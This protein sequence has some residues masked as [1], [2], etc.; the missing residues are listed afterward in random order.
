MHNIMASLKRASKVAKSVVKK[1]KP[2]K[3]GKVATKAKK[4]AVKKSRT[5]KKSRATHPKLKQADTE[6]CFWVNNGPIIANLLDL[7]ETLDNMSDEQFSYHTLSRG[8][9]F[10]IWIEE[11]IC[12][13]VLAKKIAR[14]KSKDA[15]RKAIRT[16]LK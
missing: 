15:M 6:L 16:H 10:A 2:A 1:R 11:V 5:P 8:N 9:D 13:P 12:E 3:K 14:T 7:Y 4:V